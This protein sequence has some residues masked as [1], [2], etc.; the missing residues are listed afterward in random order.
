[1]NRSRTRQVVRAALVFALGALACRAQPSPLYDG[2]DGATCAHFNTGALIAWHHR[3]GDWRDR[4]GD[5]QGEKAFSNASVQASDAGRVVQWDVTDLVRQWVEGRFANDGFLVTAFSARER[6]A[7]VFHSR[8]AADLSQRPALVVE[9]ADGASHHLSASADTTLDCT[10]F[11]SLGSRSALTAG[12]EHRTLL[13][14][15]LSDFANANVARA[16]LE[17][18]VQ[19][20]YGDATLGVFAVDA[21]LAVPADAQTGLAARYRADRGIAKDPAVLMATGFDTPSWREAWSYVSARSS[22]ERVTRA[23]A[24]GFEPLDGAALMVKIPAAENLGVDMGYR[25]ADKQRAEPEEIYFRYYLRLS[26]DWMPTLDGGK[27]PGISATYGQAGW[28]GRRTDGSRGWSMRG[29]F[30]PTPQPGNPYHARSPIG[31]YAYHV[32]MKDDT[33]DAWPWSSGGQALLERNRWYCIEQYFKINRIGQRDGVLR[34]WIDGRLVFERMD[35]RV[36]DVSSIRIEQ[37]WMNVYFGGRQPSPTDLHLFID[38]VVVARRYIGP[39][40]R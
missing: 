17:L 37:I 8:E 26:S 27:L 3:Q 15:D 34:A 33:G 19:K 7:V 24:L 4:Y 29:S 12:L 5:A 11:A 22:I 18:T 36:R 14:F 9:L 6:G 39:M 40:G 1:V 32:D 23:P 13:Q 16:T 28:G 31:T 35:V 2:A 10:T 20:P 25:L 21:P 38:N 30:Y